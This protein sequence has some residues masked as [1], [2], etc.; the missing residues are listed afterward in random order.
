MKLIGSGKTFFERD[1]RLIGLIG[2]VLTLAFTLAALEVTHLPFIDSGHVYTAYFS[3]AGGLST[4]DD[5]QVAGLDVGKVK[6]IQ[7]DG[8]RVKVEVKVKNP[9]VELGDQ[10]TARIITLNL[11]GRKAVSL[12]SKGDHSMRNGG[13]FV[14]S[15]APY[16]LTQA[17]EG[18]T[19]TVKDLDVTKVS[20]ALDSISQTFTHTPA[21]VTG[22]LNGL[23]Q[24]SAAVASRDQ[25]LNNLLSSTKS[26]TSVLAGRNREISLLFDNGASLLNELNARRDAINGL[27]ANAGAV[28]QQLSGLVRDQQGK[29]A[30]ALKELRQTV[31]L[32]SAN[33]V[34]LSQTIDRLG[35]YAT[36][37]GDAVGSGPFYTAYI[38]NLSDPSTLPVF[39]AI[40]AEAVG[41]K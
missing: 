23:R 5:V 16:D 13:A 19:T 24:V 3:D 26:V 29:L 40:L 14:Q 1:Q 20:A 10:S 25:E 30:P 41:S 39:P 2:T 17:L 7:I 8:Q 9:D 33:K 31:Q 11:L 21:G 37:L 15:I 34:K 35:P 28:A 32:L 38:P 6:S 4:G 12:E 22:A 18:V 27:L 36:A